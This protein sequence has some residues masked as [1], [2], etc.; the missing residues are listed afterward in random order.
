MKKKVICIDF[1]GCIAQYVGDNAK[2]GE[3]GDVVHGA[4]NATKVL[5][6]EGYTIII[7]TCRKDSK[8]LRKYLEENE[9]SY[10]YINENPDQ[11]DGT[12]KGKPMADLYV[13]DRAVRFNGEWKWT[14]HDVA[15]FKPAAAKNERDEMKRVFDDYR[16][17]SKE[18]QSLG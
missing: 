16:K 1:D 11:P 15:N 13:D 10:D 8:S 4:S 9:I 14:L 3:Y 2:D 7:F 5:K 6:E 12:N 17:Y 18:A